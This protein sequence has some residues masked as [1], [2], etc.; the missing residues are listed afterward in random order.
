MVIDHLLTGLI[1]HLHGR[2]DSPD[3][4]TIHYLVAKMVAS[5]QLDIYIYIYT[6][7]LC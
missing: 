1:L 2:M 3:S 6:Y 5:N 7:K 4:L